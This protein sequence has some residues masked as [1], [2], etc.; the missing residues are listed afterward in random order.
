[1]FFHI[2]EI[3]NYWFQSQYKSKVTAITTFIA[4]AV[5][6]LYKV[7]LLINGA[8]V[9]WFAF[10]TSLDYVCV[11]VL[12]YLTFR[13]NNG[14]RLSF[15]K[16]KAKELL[17]KSYHYILAGVM[18]SIYGQTDKF[19]LKH[20]LDESSVGYYSSSTVIC[21]MWTFVLAAIIDAMVPRIAELHKKNKEEY[22]KKNRQLYAIIFYASV[23]VS[24]F[25]LIFGELVIKIL[26]GDSYLPAA[27][28]L[29]VIT[30]Y[31]AFSYLG[32]A[33]NIWMVCENKQK[34]LKYIYISAA[35]INVAMNLMFIPKWGTSGAALAS[36]ITQMAT[37]I[38][39]PFFIK[40]LRPNAKLMLEA[41]LLIRVG[42]VYPN[43]P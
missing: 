1:L 43:Q 10:A 34:Y 20:M 37:S 18:V 3:F 31:T 30:W 16:T 22:L 9:Y 8:D 26:Y 36:L 12:L 38:I 25:F 19:M 42:K 17:S 28:P 4:Y 6:S 32:T 40:D 21:G 27:A 33:R 5:V 39:L 15:S 23:V 41:I 11:A 35:I 13:R 29:K 14:P 7:I 2:F 24:C